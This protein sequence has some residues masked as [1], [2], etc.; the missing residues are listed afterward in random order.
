[1]SYYW[2]PNRKIKNLTETKLSYDKLK[3]DY[4]VD[5][6]DW[7]LRTANES[8]QSK[9]YQGLCRVKYII[10]GILSYVL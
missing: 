1:M 2:N 7:E 5:K 6:R 9:K 8:E 3:V 10:A 4:D